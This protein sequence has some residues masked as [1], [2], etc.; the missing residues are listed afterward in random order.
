MIKPNRASRPLTVPATRRQTLDVNVSINGLEGVAELLRQLLTHVTVT[1]SEPEESLE[2][3]DTLGE[4][5]K[6]VVRPPSPP[7]DP[8]TGNTGTEVPPVLPSEAGSSLVQ[9]YELYCRERDCTNTASSI[10][11]TLSGLRH[12]DR[13]LRDVELP[14]LTATGALRT[15]TPERALLQC[16]CDSFILK[17]F[18]IAQVESGLSPRTAMRKVGAVQK[19]LRQLVTEGLLQHMPEEPDEGKLQKLAGPGAEFELP[20]TVEVEEMRAIRKAVHV[21]DWPNIPGAKPSDYWLFAIDVCATFGPRLFDWFCYSGRKPGVLW[22]HVTLHPVCPAPQL[23]GFEN[24]PGWVHLPIGKSRKVKRLYPLTSLLR[25]HFDRW[26][27][28]RDRFTCPHD[29]CNC[30][31]RVVPLPV[32]NRENNNT[33]KKIVKAAGVDDRIVLSE[34]R[35]R[36]TFRKGNANLW[37]EVSE[38]SCDYVQGRTLKSIQNRNYAQIVR[39]IAK[40]VHSIWEP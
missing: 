5:P 25:S 33:W 26:L 10:A 18:A 39:R 15:V 22:D 29:S 6:V 1:V 12:F 40:H 7:D 31:E 8:P 2:V 23:K 38:A 13:W 17:R 11:S 36:P 3:N 34:G 9:W 28:V 21:A 4:Q 14:R 32:N 20:E 24:P 19:V 35:G 16:F 30:R 27:V 37:S